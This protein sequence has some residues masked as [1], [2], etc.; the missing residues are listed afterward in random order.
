MFDQSFHKNAPL[1]KPDT[2]LMQQIPKGFYN[3][4][5]YDIV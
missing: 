5:F 3:F 1:Q 2:D 4:L